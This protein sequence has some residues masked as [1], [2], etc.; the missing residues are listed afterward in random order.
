[1]KWGWTW[2]PGNAF[3]PNMGWYHFGDFQYAFYHSTLYYWM[4]RIYG[5][6]DYY[7]H[8]RNHGHAYWQNA[9][10]TK[11]NK[12][13]PLPSYKAVPKE[14]QAIFKR[15]DRT[16]VSNIQN[17]LGKL[18]PEIEQAVLKMPI[19][20]T[21]PTGQARETNAGP[22][23]IIHTLRYTNITK[24]NTEKNVKTYRDWNPDKHW[25]LQNNVTVGY[26]SK[27]NETVCPT[28]GLRSNH[29]T[30]QQM[31]AID[32]GSRG[33]VGQ[34]SNSS[35]DLGIGNSSG[36]SN[37]SDISYNPGSHGSGPA[38]FSSSKGGDSQGK[39]QEKQ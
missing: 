25:G 5:G 33:N 21:L 17:R 26:S 24:E 20:E 22:A 31:Q 39:A 32:T 28:L 29:M 14:I 6:F 1:M 34:G 27:T 38:S 7:C 16:P 18:S 4:D 36:Q 11:F 15:M 2:I 10:E 19:K 9:Y 35:I 37:S 8:Y 30:R 3:T 23:K 13:A 12:K